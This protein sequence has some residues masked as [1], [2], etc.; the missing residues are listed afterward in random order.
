[1][2]NL[3]LGKFIYYVQQKTVFII[4][5]ILYGDQA[6][7]FEMELVPKIRHVRRG[8][9]SFV[10]NGSDQLGSQFFITLADDLD[11]LDAKHCVFGQVGEGFETL[12]NYNSAL[13][14]DN[15]RPFRDIRY[16]SVCNK[17]L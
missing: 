11:Y 13:V 15:N 10:N 3:F 9:I 14:D 1:V 2:G 8:L 16:G 6:R 12:D 5:S 7:Y 4:Y 17:P